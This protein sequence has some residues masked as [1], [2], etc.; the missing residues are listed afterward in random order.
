MISSTILTLF[1]VSLVRFNSDGTGVKL[2]MIILLGVLIG[3]YITLLYYGVVLYRKVKEKSSSNVYVTKELP[4][5]KYKQIELPG[6]N[7]SV[8]GQFITNIT[9]FFHLSGIDDFLHKY[10]LNLNL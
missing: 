5:P 2:F 8:F 3:L 9:G 4:L 7:M 10:N 6:Q 1:L